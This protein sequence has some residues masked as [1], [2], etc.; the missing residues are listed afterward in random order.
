ME[1]IAD[2]TITGFAQNSELFFEDIFGFCGWITGASG[3][4]FRCVLY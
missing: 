3:S 2:A 4:I 1:K